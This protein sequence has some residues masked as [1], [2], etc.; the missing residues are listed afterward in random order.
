[1]LCG[2]GEVNVEQPLYLR[3][4][5]FNQV[6]APVLLLLKPLRLVRGKLRSFNCLEESQNEQHICD[7]KILV[8]LKRIAVLNQVE[9]L[10][11][12]QLLY[13]AQQ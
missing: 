10:A 4:A 1:M 12:V 7:Y 3:L 9:F 8:A 6:H 5:V 13:V 11:L 2:F